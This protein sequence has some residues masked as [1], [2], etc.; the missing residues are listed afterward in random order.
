MASLLL[1]F[2]LISL[3][4]SDA[5]TQQNLDDD[6]EDLL[7]QIRRLSMENVGQFDGGFEAFEF[8]SREV[9][10][11]DKS[12]EDRPAVNDDKRMSGDINGRI[13]GDASILPL[14]GGSNS[15][16]QQDALEECQAKKASMSRQLETLQLQLQDKTNSPIKTETISDTGGG[17][18]LLN[19]LTVLRQKNQDLKRKLSKC[20][21]KE[22]SDD[23]GSGIYDGTIRS[24]DRLSQ[25]IEATPKLNGVEQTL[26]VGSPFSDD[27]GITGDISALSGSTPLPLQ[28][29]AKIDS[30][31]R[32]ETKLTECEASNE[33]LKKN[34]KDVLK[35]SSLEVKRAAHLQ[36]HLEDLTQ[37]NKEIESVLRKS[38]Q[39]CEEKLK[40]RRN[41]EAQRWRDRNNQLQVD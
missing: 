23:L 27:T 13:D 40:E 16:T 38:E 28:L 24:G 41:K 33:Q 12:T 39:E 19:E 6:M 7:Q 5:Y 3:V 37:K 25:S 29:R 22:S 30:N 9:G 1:V 32:C 15:E 20:N 26:G 8:M 2:W 36:Q 31:D 11:S 35:T 10:G 4:I 14:S 17:D 18:Q 34:L 21:C